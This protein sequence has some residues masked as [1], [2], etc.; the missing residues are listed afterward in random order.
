MV[1]SGFYLSSSFF[2]AA[3]AEALTAVAATINHLQ[4][5]HKARGMAK[6]IGI[7]VFLLP[8][9]RGRQN[10]CPFAINIFLK[11]TQAQAKTIQPMTYSYLIDGECLLE[12]PCGCS[13]SQADYICH[14]VHYLSYL[15]AVPHINLLYLRHHHRRHNCHSHSQNQIPAFRHNSDNLFRHL[16]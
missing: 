11:Q 3:A 12:E 16:K 10:V 4:K 2:A 13:H 15:N 8:I 7:I 14:M 9:K 1:A 6:Y 5:H